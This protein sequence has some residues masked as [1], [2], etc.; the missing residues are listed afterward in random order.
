MNNFFYILID[1]TFVSFAL[2]AMFNLFDLLDDF[3]KSPKWVS[4]YWERL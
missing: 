1:I 4:G 2:Y 3:Q